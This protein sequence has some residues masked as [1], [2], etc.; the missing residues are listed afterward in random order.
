MLFYFF[1]SISVIVIII[2]RYNNEASTK[3]HTMPDKAMSTVVN[4]SQ[5]CFFILSISVT[6]LIIMD[7]NTY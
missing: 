1:H 2:I 4:Y 3:T 6:V 7:M 5:I